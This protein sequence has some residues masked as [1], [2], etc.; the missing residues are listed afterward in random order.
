MS[1]QMSPSMDKTKERAS[2]G[3]RRAPSPA[4]W[5]AARLEITLREVHCLMLCNEEHALYPRDCVYTKARQSKSMEHVLRF[6]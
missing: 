2:S 1:P 6:T 4:S 3:G 5:R